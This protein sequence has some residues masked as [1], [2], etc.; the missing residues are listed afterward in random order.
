M[1]DSLPERLVDVP[2][3]AAARHN[4]ALSASTNLGRF[5]PNI[6]NKFRIGYG[7][8]NGSSGY[9]PGDVDEVAY[10]KRALTGGEATNLYAT[11]ITGSAST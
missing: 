8:Y 3:D 6:G 7:S 5:Q 11:A 4:G 1:I 9:F 2:Y 10:F